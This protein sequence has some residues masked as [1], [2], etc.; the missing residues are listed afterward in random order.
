MLNDSDYSSQQVRS[1]GYKV[2]EVTTQ[3]CISKELLSV[4]LE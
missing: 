1:S 3:P 4:L 2:L